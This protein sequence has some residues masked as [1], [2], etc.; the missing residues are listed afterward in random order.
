MASATGQQETGTQSVVKAAFLS[1]D[2]RYS[3]SK[4]V[5]LGILNGDEN[6]EPV[7]RAHILILLAEVR[8]HM[9]QPLHAHNHSLEALHLLN[10]L[11]QPL[12]S[13][14]SSLPSFPTILLSRSTTIDGS[15]DYG[16]SSTSSMKLPSNPGRNSGRS[17]QLSDNIQWGR[18]CLARSLELLNEPGQAEEIFRQMFI[19][20]DQ[21]EGPRAPRT[22][23]VSDFHSKQ[24]SISFSFPP[25]FID[26][27]PYQMMS[28]LGRNL[29]FFQG[30]HEE[31]AILLREC[32]KSAKHAVNIWAPRQQILV[33]HISRIERSFSSPNMV[34]ASM[35]ESPSRTSDSPSN[36]SLD[37]DI[38]QPSLTTL[39]MKVSVL[40]C[41]IAS[42]FSHM[43]REEKR[44]L[45]DQ[46]IMCHGGGGGAPMSCSMTIITSF[47]AAAAAAASKDGSKKG[48][49]QKFLPQNKKSNS[50][51]GDLLVDSSPGPQRGSRMD[52]MKRR[53]SILLSAAS[54]LPSKEINS[55]NTH[56]MSEEVLLFDQ[57]CS[58]MEAACGVEH[59]SSCLMRARAAAG[60]IA[61]GPAVRSSGEYAAEGLE[62][63]SYNRHVSSFLNSNS[64]PFVALVS[65]AQ[66]NAVGSPTQATLDAI[67]AIRFE[68]ECLVDCIGPH[69]AYAIDVRTLL[70]EVLESQLLYQ[71]ALE[72]WRVVIAGRRAQCDQAA[73]D[74]EERGG[75]VLAAQ[76]LTQLAHCQS[77]LG[78]NQE[79]AST[80]IEAAAEFASA[81]GRRGIQ[82]GQA[83][84]R[85]AD[86][87]R[88]VGDYVGAERSLS[89]AVE[90]YELK[91]GR[92]NWRTKE[93][94]MACVE[95]IEAQGRSEMAEQLMTEYRLKKSIHGREEEAK[96]RSSKP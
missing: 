20:L 79:A 21:Q 45:R 15:R 36:S 52:P 3:E 55:G 23:R 9:G 69:H 1:M 37:Q 74:N 87:Q 46:G 78:K 51:V 2:G 47:R 5:L 33:T 68:A 93:V 41:D 80:L 32:L 43:S 63:E 14:A 10:D 54:N 30:R 70:A 40:S 59:E 96:W 34:F 91:Y 26:S 53:N 86:A 6:L 83:L 76:A 48:A 92:N 85:V 84:F 7:E 24:L 17:V 57:A 42:A 66:R 94:R 27:P 62:K 56:A 13:S 89:E 75:S 28:Y 72:E 61:A 65:S 38:S 29:S 31:G 12:A 67:E 49:G 64:D 82:T 50:G 19:L 16:R 90:A 60:A 44:D 8:L 4:A 73:D 39:H 71:A 11:T 25:S 81:T 58:F 95:C 18:T 35:R 22:L 77:Q 88:L